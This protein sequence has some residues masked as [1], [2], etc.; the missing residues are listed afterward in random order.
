MEYQLKLNLGSAE[1]FGHMKMLQK[2]SYN[3][4]N[5]NGTCFRSISTDQKLAKI[6]EEKWL[7]E[8]CPNWVE[9][10]YMNK[11]RPRKIYSHNGAR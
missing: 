6:L 10:G 2:V 9:I 8:I 1:L 11:R 5:Q 4:I 3:W 7:D